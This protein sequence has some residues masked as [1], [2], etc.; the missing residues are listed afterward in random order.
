MAYTNIFLLLAGLVL[1]LK[2]SEW[3]VKSSSSFARKLGVSEFVIGLTIVAFGTSIPE[4]FSA[5][6]ASFKQ[7]SGLILGNIIGANIANLGLIIGLTAILSTLKTSR[8]IFLRD[9]YV[10]MFTCLMFFIFLLDRTINWIEASFMIILYGTYTLFLFEITSKYG[11]KS[12]FKEF[13]RYFLE[14]KYFQTFFNHL[15]QTPELKTKTIISLMKDVIVGTTSLALVLLGADII[16]EQAVF[17]AALLSVPQAAI[18]V[19]LAIG[20]TLP[21]L[22][23]ALTAIKTGYRNIAIGNAIGSCITNILFVI[24]VSGLI[25]PLAVSSYTLRFLAPAMVSIV[26][27]FLWFLKNDWKISRMEGIILLVSYLIFMISVI[28]GAIR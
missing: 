10:L 1:L 27:L 28:I 15:N 7:E 20:T 18:G 11:E 26:L 13:T 5:I 24:G 6:I 21:E 2:G 12:T 22:S 17:F 14:F 19:F 9:G 3:L 8:K 23:V 4:L 25:S 16:V